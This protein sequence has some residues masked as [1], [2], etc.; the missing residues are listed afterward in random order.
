MDRPL[1]LFDAWPR[2]PELVCDA[3]TLQRLNALGELAVARDRPLS[4]D[5]LDRYL[6]KAAIVFGETDLPAERLAR[7]PNLRAIFNVTGNFLANVDY[8]YCQAHSIYFL[9]GGTAFAV[10][11]AEAAVGMAI[12]WVRGIR[13]HDREFRVGTET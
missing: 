8:D 1:I 10:P 4:D 11:V 9:T 13:R 2:T 5:E 6:P 3:S 7:A 12:D